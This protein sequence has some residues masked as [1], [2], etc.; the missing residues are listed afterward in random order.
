MEI[1]CLSPFH[2]KIKSV[3]RPARLLLFLRDE[4][5]VVRRQLKRFR[6]TRGIETSKGVGL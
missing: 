5:F 1:H 3:C 6:K 2:R 4:K